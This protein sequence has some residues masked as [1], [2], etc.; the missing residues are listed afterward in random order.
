[1]IDQRIRAAAA[2]RAFCKD[3]AALPALLSALSRVP[4]AASTAYTAV[5]SVP[6]LGKVIGA[7]GKLPGR[8]GS[9]LTAA[10]PIARAA[11]LTELAGRATGAGHNV[12][13]ATRLARAARMAR[14]GAGISRVSRP[15]AAALMA[16]PVATHGLN[17]LTGHDPEEAQQG[18]ELDQLLSTGRLNPLYAQYLAMSNEG[19]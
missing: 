17:V 8:L 3:A 14:L 13:R 4:A 12:A 9:W 19:N 16:M 15:A 18:K 11:K 6:Y 1:M 7:I 10:K 2:T 5:K